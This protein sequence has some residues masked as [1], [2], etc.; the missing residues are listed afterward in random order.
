MINNNKVLKVTRTGASTLLP[1]ING[2]EYL[3]HSLLKCSN[4]WMQEVH[5]EIRYLFLYQPCVNL[6]L[7]TV[8]Y[9]IDFSNFWMEKRSKRQQPL[10]E[11]VDKNINE[12]DVGSGRIKSQQK[13]N[14]T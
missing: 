2:G 8:S 4:R 13:I 10:T 11:N 14:K 9:S 12:D 5:I 7:I 1:T 3:T 6:P